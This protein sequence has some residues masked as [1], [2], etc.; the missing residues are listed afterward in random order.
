MPWRALTAVGR[1]FASGE[2]PE[3]TG[4]RAVWSITCLSAPAFFLVPKHA[5]CTEKPDV[6][7]P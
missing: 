6:R 4:D 7:H 5:T 2:W 3:A 1:T